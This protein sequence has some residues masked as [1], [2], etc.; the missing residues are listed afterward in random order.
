MPED[1]VRASSRV[2]MPPGLPRPR[3]GPARVE[4]IRW[5]RDE[6]QAWSVD[7]EYDRGDVNEDILCQMLDTMYIVHRSRAHEILVR[8]MA[9]CDLQFGRDDTFDVDERGIDN[10]DASLP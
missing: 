1:A 6:E 9:Q 8:W 5:S 3:W 10:V 4:S 7:P 2:G